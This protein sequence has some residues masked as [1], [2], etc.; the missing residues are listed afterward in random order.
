[1]NLVVGLKIIVEARRQERV[2]E[3][4]NKDGNA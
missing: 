1:M 2:F 3:F 4:V